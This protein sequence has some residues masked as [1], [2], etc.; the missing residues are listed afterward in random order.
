M[1]TMYL[2]TGAQILHLYKQKIAQQEVDF[3]H[4]KTVDSGEKE[5]GR[6]TVAMY[7]LL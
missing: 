2:L 7:F 3:Y 6:K 4:C 1:A 5:E